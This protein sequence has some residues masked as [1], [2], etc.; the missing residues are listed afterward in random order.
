[1]NYNDS[2]SEPLLEGCMISEKG[3]QLIRCKKEG[4]KLVCRWPNELVETFQ[5][6]DDVLIGDKTKNICGWI[7][8]DGTIAWSTGNFWFKTGK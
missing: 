7:Q 4:N 6:D 1:M 8:E 3:N 2:F 5:I